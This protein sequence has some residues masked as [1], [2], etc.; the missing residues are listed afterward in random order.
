V[1]PVGL[2]APA[3]ER[4]RFALSIRRSEASSTRLRTQFQHLGWLQ[5]A[6]VPDAPAAASGGPE[7]PNRPAGLPVFALRPSTGTPSLVDSLHNGQAG[8]Q[9][10][11]CK[12]DAKIASRDHTVGQQRL[13]SPHIVLSHP[14]ATGSAAHQYQRSAVIK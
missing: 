5:S 8:E 11:S 6:R 2:F 4:A 9:Q 10:A 12:I 1:V 14:Q 13:E 3:G 7:A